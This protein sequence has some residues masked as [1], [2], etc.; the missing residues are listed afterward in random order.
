[1]PVTFI[2]HEATPVVVVMAV[3]EPLWRDLFHKA[4]E[5]SVVIPVLEDA[6]IAVD[7]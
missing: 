2:R 3:L 7:A 5:F 6:Q 4:P 1:M